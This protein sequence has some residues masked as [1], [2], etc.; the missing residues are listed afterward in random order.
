[1]E[2]ADWTRESL[3]TAV[4]FEENSTAILLCLPSLQNWD[5]KGRTSP[6][7]V[8]TSILKVQYY[9]FLFI[10]SITRLTY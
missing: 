1:M 8:S 6:L 4:V 5:V 9:H 10:I 7:V 2:Y 3:K